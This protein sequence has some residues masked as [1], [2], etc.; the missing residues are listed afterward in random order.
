MNR[1]RKRTLQLSVSRIGN[2]IRCRRHVSFEVCQVR[3]KVVSLDKIR[4]VVVDD[5]CNVKSFVIL[6]CGALLKDLKQRGLLESTLVVFADENPD[7]RSAVAASLGSCQCDNKRTEVIA[8][9]EQALDLERVD[10]F[11]HSLEQALRRVR[12]Q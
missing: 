8:G 5:S 9:L 4:A 10:F 6:W 7:L 12:L 3:R 11:R 1:L 2:K